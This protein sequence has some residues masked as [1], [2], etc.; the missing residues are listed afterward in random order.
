[1]EEGES[2]A[3]LRDHQAKSSYKFGVWDLGFL[4]VCGFFF[5]FNA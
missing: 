4:L 2:S 1:M 5:F 3:V